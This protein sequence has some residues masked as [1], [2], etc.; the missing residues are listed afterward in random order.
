LLTL[1]AKSP[2]DRFATIGDVGRAISDLGDEPARIVPLDGRDASLPCAA[3]EAIDEKTSTALPRLEDAV[4]IVSFNPDTMVPSLGTISPKLHGGREPMPTRLGR[5]ELLRPLGHGGMG[6]VYLARDTLLDRPVALKVLTGGDGLRAGLDRRF[7]VEARAAARLSNTGI[8]Q[9]H[10]I[11]EQDDALFVALEYVAGG[12]LSDRLS[13]EG[14]MSPAAA[15]RLVLELAR[16]VHA[17]HEQGIIHRDLKPGNILLT[18]SGAPKIAD[19]GLA[20]LMDQI[21]GE[22]AVQTAQGALLGTPSYMAPEQVRGELDRIGAATDIYGLGTILYECLTGRRPFQGGSTMSALYRIVETPPPPPRQI[23][24]DIPASLERI[25][26]K[27]LE[28]DPPKRYASASELAR[29]LEQFLSSQQPEETADREQQPLGEEDN[30][31]PSTAP[32][33]PVARR[34]RWLGLFRW[35]GIKQTPQGS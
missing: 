28:K 32:P 15:A 20:K 27:C 24:P 7:Q 29:A 19:F 33:A 8:V 26:L 10:D 17:A 30:P 1:L 23:R 16:A 3:P 13:R 2:A 25:C 22:E 35:L 21:R 6:T 14:P 12:D 18:E 11:G 34:T 4:S 31:S 5:Y 9:I